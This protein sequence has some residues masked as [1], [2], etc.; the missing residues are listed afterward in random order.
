MLARIV[1]RRWGFTLIELLVVIAIIAILAAMLLPALASAREKARRS[2]CMNNMNQFG[3]ALASYN[4]DYGD[5]FPC[6]PGWGVA[7]APD[8][9]SRIVKNTYQYAYTAEGGFIKAG[10]G[11]TITI[12]SS[13]G[14]F[15]DIR[16]WMNM[17][18]GVYAWTWK[19]STTSPT[20]AA[21]N[22]NAMPVGVGTLLVTGHMPDMKTFY[23]PTAAVM[24][25]DV[26]KRSYWGNWD[27]WV[28]TNINT[29]KKLGGTDGAALLAGDWTNVT[30]INRGWGAQWTT[31]KAIGGS[32][33]YRNQPFV[34]DPAYSGAGHQNAFSRV[35]AGGSPF[36]QNLCYTYNATAADDDRNPC[37]YWDNGTRAIWG[38]GYGYSEPA[39]VADPN[40]PYTFVRGGYERD[41]AVLAQPVGVYPNCFRKT[42]KLL[43]GR[44]LM[45]DRWGK[46]AW[47]ATPPGNTTNTGIVPGDGMLGHKDG[48][49]V[50]YGDNHVAW[51]PDPEQFFIWRNS[52]DAAS[53]GG[54]L[55]GSSV[56][57]A[58]WEVS[59]GVSDWKYFDR[60]AGFDKKTAIWNWRYPGGPRF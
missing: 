51:T 44:T 27:C 5:Y 43:A 31:T 19:N 41:G 54:G 38:G 37:H 35:T 20:F 10:G 18:H 23:C 42:S 50:L 26:N 28:E 34:A 39:A 7:N 2:N 21:G 32:Y 58:G 33:A 30:A 11:T 40:Y 16:F 57:T 8:P 17:V 48:Y 49:N 24:D 1:A 3:Q 15:A 60:F 9:G 6:D 25:Y 22:L 52:L 36:T 45:S 12:S 13:T 53:N 46:P 55:I 47:Y 14:P 59:A 56:N 4:G 29:Y